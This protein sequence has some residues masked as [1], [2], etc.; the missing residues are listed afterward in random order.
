MKRLFPF[1][2]ALLLAAGCGLKTASYNDDQA[3]PLSE[4]QG[5]SLILSVSVEYPVKG[6]SQEALDRMTASILDAAFD[7][8][9]KSATV[10]ETAARYEDNLKDE[11]FNEYEGRIVAGDRTWE[12]R[13]IGFFSGKYK[14]FQS[15][16][17]DY[18]TSRGGAHGVETLTPMVFNRKTGEIVPEEVFFADGYRAG[19]AGLIQAHLLEALDNDEDAL[20]AINEPESVG[21]NGFYEVDEDGVTW[22]YQPYE[23]APFSMDVIIV[24]VP[25]SEIKGFVRK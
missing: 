25:W 7:M 14:G 18:Y 21:P 8:E 19:V 2:A 15:Y 13:V 5:D 6:V 20:A 16:M 23:I 1:A 3:I 17:V 24:T 10:E 4:G 11:Y 22:Y 12:D 9:E